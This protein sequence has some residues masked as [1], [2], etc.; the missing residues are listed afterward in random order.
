M[1]YVPESCLL[2]RTHCKKKMWHIKHYPAWAT[3]GHRRI[4]KESN[5]ITRSASFEG[6]ALEGLLRMLSDVLNAAWVLHAKCGGEDPPFD[7]DTVVSAL[8]P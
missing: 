5:V 7:I 2:Y 3:V 1:R 8:K 4:T 6:M